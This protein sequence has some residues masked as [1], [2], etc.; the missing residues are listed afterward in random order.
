MCSCVGFNGDILVAQATIFFTAG[1]ET[2]SSTISFGL[3]ELSQHPDVQKRLR[4]EI[5]QTL[6][7][8]DGQLTYDSIKEMVYM[9]MVVSEIL[10]MHPIMPYVDRRATLS[11]GQKTYSFRP[12][13]DYEMPDAFGVIVPIA[14]IQRDAKYFPDPDRFDPERFAPE[15]RANIMPYT[16]MPF[17]V[18][19]RGCIGERFGWMQSKVGFAS[20]LRNHYVTA[21]SKM[22]GP[23]EYSRKSMFL[24]TEKGIY[25]NVVRDPLIVE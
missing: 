6:L 11:A 17:G 5:K 9:H 24:Q 14:A 23:L 21:S 13:V 3:Y 7:K 15:N 2:S 18:G 12:Y 8:N 25:V 1:F 10:R 22:S 19:P 16:F 20:F 4:A